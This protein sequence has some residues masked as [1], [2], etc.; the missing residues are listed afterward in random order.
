M[1]YASAFSRIFLELAKIPANQF[2]AAIRYAQRRNIK[3]LLSQDQFI[4]ERNKPCFYCENRMCAPSV[5]GTGLDRIDNNKG[6]ELRNVVSCCKIC[7]QIKGDILTVEETKAAIS[8]VLLV[9]YPVLLGSHTAT[10]AS[11]AK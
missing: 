3:F 4:F 5:E 8:A 11:S 1:S 2:R 9:R 7:N 6:Y 10:P